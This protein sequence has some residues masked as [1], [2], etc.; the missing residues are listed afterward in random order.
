MGTVEYTSLDGVLLYLDHTVEA[1][2]ENHYQCR[3]HKGLYYGAMITF[4]S[5]E[6]NDE[7][8]FVGGLEN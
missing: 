1:R 5:M 2:N 6:K 7:E 4:D 8:I 3:T